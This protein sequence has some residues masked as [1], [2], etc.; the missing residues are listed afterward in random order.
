MT[1]TKA[2]AT[3][4]HLDAYLDGLGKHLRDK[5][6]RAS[7]A[8]YALGLLSDGERKSMEPMATRACGTPELAHAFHERLVHFTTSAA[9]RDAPLRRYATEHAVDEMQQHGPIRTWVVDDTGFLKQGKQSPGVQRQYTG[10]AGKTTNCQVGVSLLLA[11]D[12]A[13]VMTDFRLYIP[14][15]WTQDRERCR[16]ARIPDDVLYEPKWALA[17][18]MIEEAKAAGLPEGVVL[19]DCDYGNKTTF[20]DT[21]DAPQLQYALD[22]QS[23]TMLRRVGKDGVLG[24]RMSAAQLG[25]LLSGELSTVTWRQG[26]KTAM[27]SRFARTRVVVDRD[28]GTRREPQ[29]LLIEWPVGEPAPTK[30][31]LSTLPHSTSLKQMV[32]TFKSRWRIERAY[33]DLKGELGL[34]HYEGRSFIGWHHHVTVVLACYAFLV[35]EHARSFPP[36]TRRAVHDN[37]LEHA[38]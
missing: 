15:S 23:T 19:G 5:R 2:S 17:L 10:S 6:Q 22:V 14:E 32:R 4:E 20:R 18:S 29:W 25:V 7:F 16:A 31:V 34:D 8:M 37:A 24:K 27:R 1:T 36:S 28:D 26:S 3:A 9:W 33:E 21:L 11:T 35:A 30:F 13:H 38:A 12:H